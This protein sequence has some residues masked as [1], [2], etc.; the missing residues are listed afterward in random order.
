LGQNIPTRQTG[1]TNLAL[2][3][4]N[5]DRV[6]EAT[7]LARQ[8]SAAE[9]TILSKVFSFTSEQQRLAYLDIFHPYILF[10]L[11]KGTETDLAQAALRY[12][13]VV[14]DSIVEDRLLAEASQGSEEQK[15]VERLNLD[16]RQLGQ[17]SDRILAVP[18]LPD[19]GKM[20]TV[21]RSHS[22]APE[23]CTPLDSARQ[24]ER[25]RTCSATI[26]DVGSRFGPR[27]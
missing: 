27:R 16:K 18:A 4:F 7:P 1:L 19:E 9:L 5:L 21:L 22:V 12:K 17:G 2:L 24:S 20:G 3:E 8:A 11:L 23:G 25:D 6:D 13:G 10:A 15:L 26:R 14:L